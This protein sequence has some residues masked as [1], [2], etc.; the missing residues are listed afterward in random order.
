M[1]LFIVVALL[2]ATLAPA[3][4]IQTPIAVAQSAN[5]RY[6]VRLVTTEKNPKAAAAALGKQYALTVGHTYDTALKGF[7]ATIPARA[8]HGL[9]RNPRV[10]AIEPDLTLT[11]V[12]TPKG[13]DRVGAENAGGTGSPAGPGVTVAVLDTGV[14]AHPDLNLVGGYNCTTSDTTAYNDGHGHGTHVAGTVGANGTIIGVA[15]GT[16]ILAVKVLSDSGSGSWSSI[17]CGIDWVA[18]AGNGGVPRATVANISLGGLSSEDASTCASSSLH[19]AL[20]NATANGVTFAVAAGNDGIDAS[21]FVPAKYPEVVTVAALADSDGC[22]GGLGAATG[23]GADDTRASFSNYGSI[24]DVAAPGVSIYS[25]VPGG[26]GYM[27]GTSMASPHVAGMLALGGYTTTPSSFTIPIAV[28]PNGDISCAGTAPNTAITAAPPALT[29]SPDATFTFSATASSTFECKLDA[30]AWTAC[31]GPALTG[32]TSYTALVD[33]SHTFSVR[34][35]ANIATD[36]T[37]AV[38]TWVIDTI[39]PT[40]AITAP[41]DGSV[42][43]TSQNVVVAAA[44]GSGSGVA[45]VVVEARPTG[46]PWAAVA[47]ADT[48]APY[49]ALWITTALTSGDSELRAIVTDR[50]GN[51][52][53]SPLLTVTVAVAPETI[54]TSAPSGLVAVSTA[55]IV[56]SASDPSATFECAVDGGAWTACQ[57]P[58]E[59]TGLADQAHTVQVRSIYAAGADGTPAT[60][61][62]T[63]D[64][65]APSIVV[66]APATAAGSATLSATATD[67]SALGSVRFE[68]TPDGTGTFTEISRD[69]SAPYTATWNVASLANGLYKVRAV[70]TDAAGNIGQSAT[71]DVTVANVPA[72]IT[73]SPTS[74]RSGA[75]LTVTGSGFRPGETVVIWWDANGTKKLAQVRASSTGTIKATFKVPPRETLGAHQIVALGGTSGAQASSGFT[76]IP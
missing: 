13:V 57:S 16:P 62:W 1:A 25:T 75:R 41:T 37:P 30:G 38:S 64:T 63:S 7:A 43:S 53:N 2:A 58:L 40:G 4:P 17:L 54:I 23:N 9:S 32:T 39:A 55:T 50:A 68:Y 22:A 59:L 8:L 10:F 47:D 56:F 46:G 31:G 6:I 76:L 44:D 69:S 74:G 14:A 18:R 42:I 65:T 15:P 28:V 52:T 49:E 61:T 21:G 73:V 51:A 29:S 3:L 27:S 70:V 11:I 24:V 33:G 60:A 72:S 5:G 36:G 26:Y 19:Q 34:A 45:S 67:A 71:V 66:S 48:S 20:C 35:T 12:A